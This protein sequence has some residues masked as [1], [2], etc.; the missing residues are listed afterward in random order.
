MKTTI[1][2][3]S[4]IILNILIISGIIS[5]KRNSA[6]PEDPDPHNESELITTVMITFNGSNGSAFTYAWRD[7]DGP[8]GSQPTIDTIRLVNG[9]TYQAE[10]QFL[11]ESGDATIDITE[12]IKEE[13]DEH[14]VCYETGANALD[15]ETTDKDGN[16]YPIGI[17]T[18]WKTGA[19]AT[20]EVKVVLKHQ[21]GQKDGT[22]DPGETDVEVVFPVVIAS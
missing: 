14:L 18:T 4:I 22:C 21:P 5:C 12:E 13:A 15:I 6:D 8:G 9:E 7:T 20:T 2:N 19:Q 10:V 16:N 3:T 1:K 11:D 17:E